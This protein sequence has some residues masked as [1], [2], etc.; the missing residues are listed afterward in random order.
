M[1][2]ELWLPAF[3]GTDFLPPVKLSRGSVVLALG[4]GGEAAHALVG[5]LCFYWGGGLVPWLRSGRETER[6]QVVLVYVTPR[7]RASP[8]CSPDPSMPPVR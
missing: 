3:P 7:P 8:L 1:L 4:W 2:S 6:A 5:T